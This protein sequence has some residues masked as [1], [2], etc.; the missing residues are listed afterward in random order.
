MLHLLYT[1]FLTF[2]LAVKPTTS[3]PTSAPDSTS[4]DTVTSNNA[5]SSSLSA[6]FV[7]RFVS[8]VQEY[9]THSPV[10]IKVYE[11]LR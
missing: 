10:F 11:H 6:T 4:P 5:T 7:R 3:A 8:V 1:I 2:A 9:K